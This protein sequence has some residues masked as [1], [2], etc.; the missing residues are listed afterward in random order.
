VTITGYSDTLS[1][2][3]GESLEFKVSCDSAASFDAAIVRLIHG[4]THPDGP[5][6][7]EDEPETDLAPT[8]PARHQPVHSGSSVLAGDHP[9][10]RTGVPSLAAFVRPTTPLKGPQGI[11]TKW[12]ALAR[13]GYALVIDERGCAALWIG[14]GAGGFAAVGFSR[15]LTTGNWYFIA[16]SLDAGGRV[17]IEQRPL[18]AGPGSRELVPEPHA[19]CVE[20][21]QVDVVPGGDGGAPLMIAAWTADLEGARAAGHF[22]GKI[23]RPAV[24]ERPLEAQELADG[25]RDGVLAAFDFAA[26]IGPGGIRRP[27]AV[28]DRGPHRLQARCV[29]HPARAVTGFNWTSAEHSFVHAPEQYGAIHFH[30]DDLED[31]GWEPDFTFTVPPDLPS[32]IYAARLRA[33][34]DED[35][36]P[37]YVRARPGREARL[38]FLVPTAS[39]MAYANDHVTTNAAMAELTIGRT[40]VMEDA[41]LFLA[42]HREY[43]LSTYD[44]HSDGSGSAFSSRLR[45]IINMRPKYRHWLSPSVWQFNADLYVVDWLTELGYTFD[46]L[47]DEDLHR[48]GAAA[49]E[50]YDVLITGS[51]PE[52]CSGEML[53]AL[54]A[55]QARGGRMIYMGSDGFYWVIQFHP[56]SNAV[57]EVRKGDGSQ[58]W[59]AAPGE[60]H[61]SYTGEY[62]TLWR[63]RGR[64][65][66]RLCGVGWAAE[67]FDVASYFRRRPD[68]HDPRVAW[69][70]EGIEDEILGD[71]G[72]VGGGAAGLE[73]DSYDPLQGTPA[74]A[75]LLASSEGHTDTYVEV[76]EELHFNVPGLGGT[77]NPR[78]RA[79]MVYYTTP[80]GGA[81]FSTGSIAYCGSLSH[82]GY[83]NNVSRLTRNVL[84]RFLSEAPL[85]P[86]SDADTMTEGRR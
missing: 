57:I 26:E 61:L 86:L 20:Y 79:D 14:D 12:H 16:A 1:L 54:E 83:E 32:G 69:I 71:F 39:Y 28:T 58:A 72:L 6:Y 19:Q 2:R 18:P 50:P 84:D 23:D 85:P 62:G 75:L 41:D 8:W 67:G 70:F 38:G 31:A 78:V 73:L 27:S 74:H 65:P 11:I 13:G 63:H 55:F 34:E 64:A 49:L 48:E 52:Y 80:N 37:F 45:P 53:D 7:K 3:P 47:T 77:E 17:R 43:G 40:P 29:N 82:N 46:V 33:G 35:H 4:D 51:H 25:A 30:D 9:A 56:E 81:V 76:L 24:A 66:H 36:V 15:P 60:R 5:G 44:T 68:S 59:R 22:N 10:L 42:E 21:A